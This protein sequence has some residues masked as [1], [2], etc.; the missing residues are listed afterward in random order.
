M[1]FLGDIGKAIG[2]GN[3][4]KGPAGRA[5][6]TTLKVIFPVA[7]VADAASRAAIAAGK[8]LMSPQ[9]RA[10]AAGFMSPYS[11]GPTTIHY[12]GGYGA[13][14]AYSTYFADQSVYGGAQWDSSTA[15]LGTS[16]EISSEISSMNSGWADFLVSS[17]RNQ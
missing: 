17:F 1:P 8:N 4:N 15:Y 3:I 14:P 5:L 13:P 12:N 9:G 7:A 2:I 6:E 11:P 10:V 16:P